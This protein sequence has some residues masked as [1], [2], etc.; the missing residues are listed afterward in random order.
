MTGWEDK[1]SI[2]QKVRMESLL[3]LIWHT[4]RS[5][6]LAWTT[7]GQYTEDHHQPQPE[8]KERLMALGLAV[9]YQ[10]GTPGPGHSMEPY[11]SVLMLE[12]WVWGNWAWSLLCHTQ[13]IDPVLA[14]ASL[15]VNRKIVK[16]I[17]RC[18]HEAHRAK[19]EDLA[20]IFCLPIF[21]HMYQTR[22]WIS[23]C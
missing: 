1:S 21:K 10:I 7:Q 17:T 11:Q 14:S 18:S 16:L 3:M 5:P 4:E 2:I 8:I 15:R 12:I 20:E 19:L 22:V 23:K 6:V 9:S 13:L